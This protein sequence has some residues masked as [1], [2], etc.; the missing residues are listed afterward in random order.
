ME[1]LFSWPVI[2]LISDSGS[3][4]LLLNLIHIMEIT[5]SSLFANLVGP[6]PGLCG[7]CEFNDNASQHGDC[8]AAKNRRLAMT[9]VS[10]SPWDP[11]ILDRK[12]PFAG[13]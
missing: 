7:V 12:I 4:H 13:G 11:K 1:D 10:S 3:C 8:F 2:I 6:G 9:P 5:F